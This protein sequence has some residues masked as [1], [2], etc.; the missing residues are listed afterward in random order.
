MENKKKNMS[1]CQ[2]NLEQ[3]QGNFPLITFLLAITVLI[4][5]AVRKETQ[6]EEKE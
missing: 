5:A 3:S 6:Q 2:T 1:F 4:V